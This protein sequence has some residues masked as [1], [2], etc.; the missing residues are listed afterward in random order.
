M[1]IQ[2][3]IFLGTVG[4][5]ALAAS[6]DAP[7]AAS[8]PAAAGNAWD[9]SWTERVN[10]KHRAV[11]D[12]PEFSNGAGLARALVW[13]RQYKEVYGTAPEDMSAVLVLRAAGIWLVMNDAF[14]KRYDVGA[15]QDF[16]DGDAGQFLTAN[17]IASAPASAKPGSA[18][19]TIPSFVASGNIVLACHLAFG[20]VVNLVKSVDKLATSD[21]AESRAM[22]FVLPG[23]IMQPSG[24]FAALRAQ[25][26]GCSY[27]LAS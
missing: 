10:G 21:E 4:T 2:R 16:K 13:K 24:V 19:K 1:E 7:A 20:A 15:K 9:V 8:A 18:D 11:F 17:P 3:R 23:V 6:V 12:S 5:A 26:A 14:W 22:G 27:I 25:E